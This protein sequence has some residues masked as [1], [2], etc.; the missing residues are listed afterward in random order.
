MLGA[1]FIKD[2]ISRNEGNRGL[3][4][5]KD[6]GGYSSFHKSI[7]Q[8]AARARKEPSY[9][10]ATPEQLSSIRQKMQTENRRRIILKLAVAMIIT[11]LIA[12]VFY[13]LR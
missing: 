4:K 7:Y 2:M 6:S 3:V 9:K 8:K 12:Y 5:G 13:I 10:T 1:G 11:V